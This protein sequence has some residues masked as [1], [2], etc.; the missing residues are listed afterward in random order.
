MAVAVVAGVWAGTL[1]TLGREVRRQPSFTWWVVNVV[2]AGGN[3]MAS[4]SFTVTLM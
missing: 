4:A 1:T 2:R 3:E